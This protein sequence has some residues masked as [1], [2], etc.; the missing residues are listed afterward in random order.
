MHDD[1]K[2]IIGPKGN[3]VSRLWA[4]GLDE[5]NAGNDSA[6][7]RLRRAIASAQVSAS[8]GSIPVP[9][10]NQAGR[11]TATSRAVLAMVLGTERNIAG[12]GDLAKL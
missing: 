10:F 5:Y 7:L 1:D 4:I 9:A 2:E 3:E 11:T 6:R 12:R 8:A